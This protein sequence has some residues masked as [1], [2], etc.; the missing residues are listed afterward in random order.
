MR[1]LA[2][3]WFDKAAELGHN[4]APA[5]AAAIRDEIRKEEEQRRKQKEID[6]LN[7]KINVWFAKAQEGDALAQLEI[8]KC[9]LYGTG[10]DRDYKYALKFL[11]QSAD[12]GNKKA[13]ELIGD[14]YGNGWGVPV[15]YKTALLWYEKAG[16]NK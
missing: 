11:T 13:M 2:L 12:G 6:D 10:V 16:L 9:F 1:D 7:E 14:C 8:G 4:D 3:Q 5:R 15:S